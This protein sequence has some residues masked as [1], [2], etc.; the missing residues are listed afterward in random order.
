MIQGV[1]PTGLAA[2]VTMISLVCPEKEQNSNI[3]GHNRERRLSHENAGPH[4]ASCAAHGFRSGLDRPDFDQ[5]SAG[6]ANGALNLRYV[7]LG[8]NSDAFS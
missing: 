4:L 5:R 1:E 3:F 8:D 6:G 2:V 7:I